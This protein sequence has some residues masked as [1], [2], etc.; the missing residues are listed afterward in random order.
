MESLT[1]LLLDIYDTHDQWIWNTLSRGKKTLRNLHTG[2]FAAVT[3]EAF[4]N[5]IPKQA[6]ADGFMSRCALVYVPAT[7]RIYPYP[8]LP[9]KAPS[10]EELARRL[11]WIA[12]N[13][14]GEYEL[15]EGALT[16]YDKWYHKWK[17]DLKRYP[18]Y[19]GIKSRESVRVLK[20]SLLLR[21]QRY[22]NGAKIITEEDVHE[23]IKIIEYTTGNLPLLLSEIIEE[24]YYYQIMDKVTNYMKRK[25]KTKR[26]DMIRGMR[27]K[28]AEIDEAVSQLVQEMRIHVF[29]SN[30]ERIKVPRR[31]TDEVYH[32]VEP[33]TEEEKIMYGDKEEKEGEEA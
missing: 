20:L 2:L 31:K 14:M 3:V 5:S 12:C 32:W 10:E 22:E 9:E 27:F 11:A 28:T 26:V 33:L 25:K 21:C 7:S 19:Q 24:N 1:S 18:E 17:E 8:K 4:R 30:G 23:A 6:L 29:S 16:V 13:A 15:S